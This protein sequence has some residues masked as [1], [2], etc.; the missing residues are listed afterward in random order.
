MYMNNHLFPENFLASLSAE[1][2]FDEQNFVQAHQ[3]I[4]SPTSIRLNPFKPSAI[5]TDAQVPWCADGFYLDTRPSFT[6]DPLFHAGCYYVQEASSMFIDH[7]I[8][9]IRQNRE[10]PIKVLDLCAA[11]G[12]KSTLLNSAIGS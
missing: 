4:D 7:I 3:N 6:F 2:G 8:K 12:G 10:Q 5:K 11:P 9:H 1:N